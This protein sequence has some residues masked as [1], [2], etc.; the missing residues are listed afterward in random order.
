MAKA[1]RMLIDLYANLPPDSIEQSATVFDPPTYHWGHR[2]RRPRRHLGA[3]IVSWLSDLYRALL[4]GHAPPKVHD[5]YVRLEPLQ[6]D[7]VTLL[8]E[9]RCTWH[10]DVAR[11][12]VL[13][14]LDEALSAARG[15]V[16]AA[17]L[18]T[19]GEDARGT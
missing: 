18:D 19:N 2:A 4:R 5:V 8:V 13:H 9:V 3:D 11:A 6:P 14:A 1:G 15:K 7:A 10:P 16:F 17:E 12:V